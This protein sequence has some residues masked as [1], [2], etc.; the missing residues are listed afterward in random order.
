MNWLDE[1]KLNG[2][3]RK[4]KSTILFY[5]C[6]LLDVCIVVLLTDLKKHLVYNK[7][8]SV[9]D[10]RAVPLKENIA[11]WSPTSKRRRYLT[12]MTQH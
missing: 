6:A 3:R 11:S 2:P 12:E 7:G 4:L 10:L 1:Q 9:Y 5:S 8:T